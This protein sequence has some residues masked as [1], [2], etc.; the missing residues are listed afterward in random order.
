MKVHAGLCAGGPLD[1]QRIESEYESILIP[2]RIPGEAG[3]GNGCY[4]FH[5]AVQMWIWQGK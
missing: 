1:G 4:K 5:E 3:F 2:I